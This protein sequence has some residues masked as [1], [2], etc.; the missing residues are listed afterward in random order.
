[1][2][3][4]RSRAT[5]A[6]LPTNASTII[7]N[8]TGLD[9]L[10]G[11]AGN[12]TF[13]GDN[14]T[15]TA[16][17]LNGGNGA[18]K[19]IITNAG[20]SYSSVPTLT[21]I[22]T[23][24]VTDAGSTA[25]ASFNLINST[26]ITKIVNSGSTNASAAALTFNNLAAIV[27]LEI[28]STSGQVNET[29]GYVAAAVAGTTDIQ[30]VS[31]SSATMGTL[32]VAGV[33]TMAFTA[34]A[35]NTTIAAVAAA[36][37]TKATIEGS[38]NLTITGALTGATTIDASTATG[39]V[40]VQADATK[41]VAFT[42]GTGADTINMDVG[43]TSADTLNGGAGTDTLRLATQATFAVTAQTNVTNF[44]ALQ[45]DAAST[46]TLDLSL[47]GA[48]NAFK[49]VTLGTGGIDQVGLVAGQTVAIT[50]GVTGSAITVD[51]DNA[52]NAGTGSFALASDS[53]ADTL[54]L[55]LRNTD[56]TNGAT[57]NVM[58]AF[59]AAQIEA[60]TITANKAVIAGATIDTADTLN[61]ATLSAAVATSLVLSG[62]TAMSIGTAGST[63]TALTLVDAAA[64][65]N[66]IT[67]GTLA[68]AFGTANTG[69]TVNTG[70]GNDFV[71]LNVG[72]AGVLKAV[73]LGGNTGATGADTLA[74]SS[75]TGT[76][77]TIVDLSSTTDQISQLLG[78]AN[79]AAQLNIE[80]INLSGFAAAGATSQITGSSAAN[81]IVGGAGVDTINGG[82]GNDTI[83]GGLGADV[84]SGGAGA[85]RFVIAAT[86]SLNTSLDTINDFAA[87]TDILVLAVV[88]TSLV[89]G[90]A[91]AQ[92]TTAVAIAS[93]GVT[94]GALATDLAAAVTAQIA[95]NSTLWD[96]IGD[97][98][99][100]QLTGASVAGTTV[101]YIFQ[102]QAANNTYD[103]TVDT[104]VALIGTSTTPTA[105]ASFAA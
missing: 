53:A 4:C 84:L 78:S 24:Q 46:G 55:A 91:T 42:G 80:N 45:I 101:T 87:G 75:A 71:S 40:K 97:T 3:I 33:E 12:D 11:T 8:T 14:N 79:A 25:G 64:A 18:D 19:L 49:T 38:G 93:S 30:K 29:V 94:S 2:R 86:D 21:S 56:I 104:V 32:T 72:V 57:T 17:T 88:P 66:D 83:T 76:G 73:D 28:N 61:L 34:V 41:N 51:L 7:R 23:L 52:T 96:S 81:V 65:T 100:V 50:K 1:M 37:M 10:T 35:G 31:L 68:M 9:S 20:A 5:A 15:L 27:D 74:L 62:N 44:E 58:T 47:Y 59:T 22:E 60:L 98:I 39:A 69:A 26:G 105:L 48:T 85:D 102:N 43:L 77:L 103:A 82:A 13:I 70:A 67:L 95:I 54:T 90:A 92:F 89:A 63:L 99:A 16:D 36:A 6:E